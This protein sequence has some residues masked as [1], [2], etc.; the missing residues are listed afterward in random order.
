MVKYNQILQN[1]PAPILPSQLPNAKIDLAGL[2]AYARKKGVRAGDLT[3]EEKNRFIQGSTVQK[4][5]SELLASIE[6]KN[7]A[8]WNASHI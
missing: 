4:L 7:L 3:E 1:M 5:Q 2:M 8:K 6:C